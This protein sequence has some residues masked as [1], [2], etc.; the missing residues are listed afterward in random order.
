LQKDAKDMPLLSAA[1]FGVS[2]TSRFSKTIKILALEEN[3]NG[4]SSYAFCHCLM[5]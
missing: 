1:Y 2:T 3:S 5:L 4:Y